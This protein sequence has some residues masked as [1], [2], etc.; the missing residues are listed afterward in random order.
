MTSWSWILEYQA[1]DWS[2]PSDFYI[3]CGHCNSDL[4]VWVLLGLWGDCFWLD[5]VVKCKARTKAREA[6]G[7]GTGDWLV[8]RS[9]EKPR[10]DWSSARSVFRKITFPLQPGCSLPEAV[11]L[12]HQARY[13][14]SWF[15]NTHEMKSKGVLRM[16]SIHPSSPKLLDDLSGKSW[17]RASAGVHDTEHVCGLLSQMWHHALGSWELWAGFSVP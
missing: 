9:C 8:F 1:Y 15:Q 16:A 2:S 12:S 11:A 6:D 10:N 5:C 13:L 17:S 4:Q 3:S 7:L 14:G